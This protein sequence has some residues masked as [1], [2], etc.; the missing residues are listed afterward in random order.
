MSQFFLIYDDVTELV[1][2]TVRHT[3]AGEIFIRKV[4]AIKIRD[5][6]KAMIDVFA[7]ACDH[8]PVEMDIEET[9]YRVSKTLDDK[10]LTN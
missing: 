3:K 4:D 9:G 8:Q 1:V 7:L 5:L 6:A 2:D 10:I